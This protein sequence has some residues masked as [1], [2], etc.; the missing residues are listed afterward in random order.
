MDKCERVPLSIEVRAITRRALR[1]VPI[2][3]PPPGRKTLPADWYRREDMPPGSTLRYRE[4]VRV[5]RARAAASRKRVHPLS[6]DQKTQKATRDVSQ[7]L[8]Q[9]NPDRLWMPSI[10]IH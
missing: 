2:A 6:W 5:I 3:D 4:E 9:H 7:F 8:F 10:S 1:P